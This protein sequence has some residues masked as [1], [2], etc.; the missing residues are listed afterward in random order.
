MKAYIIEKYSKKEKL[1]FTQ[2]AEP[3]A[4]EN[5]VLVQIHAAGINLL[6][7]MIKK[8]EFKVFLPYKTPIINGHDM[9]GTVVKVGP[10]VKKFKIG[11]EVYSRVGDYRIGT[12]AEYIAVNVSDL[13][14]KPKN[15]TMEEAGSI[16]LVGL[17]AWQALVEI[18]N[19]KKGQ[20]VFVQAGSG[21]VGTFAI[22]LAKHLGA[23]VATTTSA[24]NIDLVKGLGADLVIDYKTQEFSNLLKDYDVVL[25]SNREKIVLEQSLGILKKGGQL[26]SLVGPPTPEF[27]QEIGLPWYLKLVT[28]FLSSS[29][30]KKAKKLNVSFKFLFMRAEGNQLGEITKL[31]EAGIIK[32]VIDKVFPFEQTNE[33]LSY[34]ETGRSKGKVVVRVK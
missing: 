5:E 1:R 11:D 7:S 25:H 31:I 9:A 22:Q 18:A 2:T 14:L 33:A 26:I 28:K 21:G 16:P 23:Y 27:A 13:S 29:A 4:K 8:G 12:F 34:V 15:L 30:R 10:G 20:K 19:V 17:T 24:K 6:D 32:P 3:I